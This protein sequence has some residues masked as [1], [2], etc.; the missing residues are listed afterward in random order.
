[1]TGVLNY[2]ERKCVCQIG[3]PQILTSEKCTAPL[4][5]WMPAS[6]LR[7]NYSTYCQKNYSKKRMTA[8]SPVK[9]N[10]VPFKEWINVILTVAKTNTLLH[11]SDGG[12]KSGE[13]SRL[14]LKRECINR[15]SKNV[16]FL[17][18]QLLSKII[19][20]IYPLKEFMAATAS[21]KHHPP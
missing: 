20:S 12:N 18:K 9:I 19:G 8:S 4:K 17:N 7:N 1:M 21:A 11:R 2:A 16:A 5:E 6:I 10:I 13:I 14:P 3:S 15:S